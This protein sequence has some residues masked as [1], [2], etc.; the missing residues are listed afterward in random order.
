MQP[1]RSSSKNNYIV[2]TY[3]DSNLMLLSRRKC[4]VSKRR[5]I[6]AT[7]KRQATLAEDGLKSNNSLQHA[8]GRAL[9][10]FPARKLADRGATCELL[11]LGL[12]LETAEWLFV[13]KCVHGL[14][15][16]SAQAGACVC[17]S[18]WAPLNKSMYELVFC[19]CVV[20]MCSHIHTCVCSLL[21]DLVGVPLLASC[22][23]P[24]TWH[25]CSPWTG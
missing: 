12:G 18:L 20:L 17:M 5:S 1:E 14:M 15:R 22:P 8:A 4:V 19:K 23:I 24:V 11:T 25:S 3:F 2:G 9:P 7:A 21:S 16:T 10:R 13:E 6:H